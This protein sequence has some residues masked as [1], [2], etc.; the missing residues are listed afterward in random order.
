MTKLLLSSALI[1]SALVLS[2][3]DVEQTEKGEMPEVDVNVE[4]GNLPEYDVDAPEVKVGTRETEVEVPDVDVNTET[5][6]VDV[7]VVGI[8]AGD[9]DEERK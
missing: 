3:C 2:A 1:G 8:E 5:K 4:E 6:K 7:P 9:V